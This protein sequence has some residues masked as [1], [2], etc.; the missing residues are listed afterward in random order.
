MLARQALRVQPELLDLLDQQA[1]PVPL[2][3]LELRAQL[4]LQVLLGLPEQLALL[5]PLGLLERRALATT[6]YAPM[7]AGALLRTP[8][9]R[10]LLR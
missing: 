6:Q 7:P 10:R 1:L 2:A 3:Q 9:R 8:A 5:G 4:E